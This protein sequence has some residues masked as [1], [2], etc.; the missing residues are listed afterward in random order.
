MSRR[1]STLTLL[2]ELGHQGT[3]KHVRDGGSF[4]RKR[5]WRPH[6]QD[7]AGAIASSKR[8][9]SDEN[10][11]ASVSGTGSGCYRAPGRV[12]R[13]KG[14]NLPDA[15]RAHYRWAGGRRLVG[16]YAAFGRTGGVRGPRPAVHLQ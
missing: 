10:S 13:R 1:W 4:R 8:E 7:R 12:A 5:A 9:E 14:S 16:N 3:K 15:A 2:S 11:P 6:S